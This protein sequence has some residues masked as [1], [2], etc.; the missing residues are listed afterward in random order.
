MHKLKLNL[1]MLRV[2]SFAMHDPETRRGTVAGHAE[3]TR[4]VEDKSDA[5]TCA[6]SCADGGS[7]YVTWCWENC[8]YTIDRDRE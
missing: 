3:L 7:C 1:D 4:P 2:E 6:R 8:W 5:D